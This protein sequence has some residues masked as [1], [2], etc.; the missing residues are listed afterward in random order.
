MSEIIGDSFCPKC[1][2][3]GGDRAGNHLMLFADGGA[4]CNR[5]NYTE[6]SGQRKLEIEEEREEE[7]V[8]DMSDVNNIKK[9][10]SATL[11]DRH[12]NA[13]TLEH[14]GVKVSVNTSNGEQDKH[15][16]PVTKNGT[17]HGYKVRALP[18]T[19]A[20]VGD[21]KGGELFGQSVTPAGAKKLVITEGEIDAMSVF[22][23]LY[24]KYPKFKPSVVSLTFG[25]NVKSV[26]D[27][28]DY[29]NS[30]DEVILCFDND[31]AGQDVQQ[32]VI[33]LVGA[34]A[35][36][37][38]LSSKDAN[39]S[40]TSGK[41]DE[42]VSAFFN[43]KIPKPDGFVTVDDVWA[44]ATAMPT[45]GKAWPWP[46]LTKLTYG[47]RLGEGIYFGAGVK[48]GKSEAVNQIVH[49]I[50]NVEKGNVAVFKLEEKPS[51]TVRKVAGKLAG[52][53]FHIPDA[54]FTQKQLEDAVGEVKKTGLVM[55]DSY[56][57][58]GW[59]SLKAA[60][61]HAVVAEGC[62]DIIIDPLTRLTNGMPAAE[63]NTELERISDEL[64]KMAKDLGFFYH[65]FAHLKAPQKGKPHEQGGQ[66]QSN[67]F[68]GSR[69]MMRAA[70]FLV[71]IERDKGAE[72]EIVRNT[73]T[74][75]LLEDRNFGNSGTF[76]VFYNRN[77]GDYL[78]PEATVSKPVECVGTSPY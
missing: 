19:F 3:S 25:A 27:N 17:V 75:V 64:S 44:E 22:Q 32:E 50:L 11:M 66:V 5:C 39:D 51:M 9:L 53:Q 24:A 14:Y 49:H 13:T 65:V 1:R 55:Y 28:I 33:D 61:R 77:T 71:G 67:Q 12:L 38:Y 74:F 46:S 76:P 62:E 23:V 56:G 7:R 43:A 69:S 16:Y 10:G 29:V 68:T 4:F 8:V 40:L 52:K 58:T 26:A 70:Y 60:I 21:T 31:Q 59:D 18:K 57:S 34:K 73:S 47:R 20:T 37:M 48:I 63:A 6:I 35:K 45:W 2:E 78:E 72:D 42:I 30:F 41:K 36:V 15:Y 54:D